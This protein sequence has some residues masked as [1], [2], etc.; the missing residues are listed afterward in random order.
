MQ[1]TCLHIIVLA[2]S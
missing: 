1:V 2:V